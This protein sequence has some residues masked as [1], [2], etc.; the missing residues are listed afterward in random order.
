MKTFNLESIRK[1]ALF[2]TGENAEKVKDQWVEDLPSMYHFDH[3][4]TGDVT[5]VRFKVL[6]K[7]TDEHISATTLNLCIPR[8]CMNL[9]D[10]ALNHLT[11]RSL[12]EIFGDSLLGILYFEN[13]SGDTINDPELAS[14]KHLPVFKKKV[15]LL[16]VYAYL[17]GTDGYEEFESLYAVEL[18]NLNKAETVKSFTEIYYGERIMSNEGTAEDIFSKPMIDF[19]DVKTEQEKQELIENFD[20]FK[21]ALAF[22]IS[23]CIP[24]NIKVSYLFL[25]E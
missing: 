2:Y 5:A 8:N 16:C 13:Q 10:G 20:K 9:S 15:N 18:R 4:I 14:F 3:L 7:L 25:F 1:D 24:V 22:Q 19:F 11:F 12:V 6:L 23:Q 21:Q 17:R